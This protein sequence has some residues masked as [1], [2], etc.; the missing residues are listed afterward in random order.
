MKNIKYYDAE[1]TDKSRIIDETKNVESLK[2]LL[3]SNL[4]IS[5]EE[6]LLEFVPKVI[7]SPLYNE[8][9]KF[10]ILFSPKGGS[11]IIDNILDEYSLSVLSEFSDKKWSTT[12]LSFLSAQRRETTIH[13]TWYEFRDICDGISKKDLIIV[14]RNPI[15]KWLSGVW[16]DINLEVETSKILYSYLKEKYSLDN[17]GGDNYLSDEAIQDIIFKYIKQSIESG[18]LAC[19]SHGAL[20]NESFFNLLT[21][22]N[23]SKD[24]I[25]IIDIDD[26]DVDLIDLFQ[27]FYPQIQRSEADK[28]FWTMRGIHKTI[29]DGL[30]K[31][32]QNQNDKLFS[33][34]LRNELH[35]DL[36]YYT[37][38]KEKYK[39]NFIL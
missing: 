37:L 25:K 8:T 23:I 27:K 14:I 26:G 15:Y 18:E 1:I 35:R 39:N 13:K 33:S 6:N 10:G 3:G 11:S 17:M 4:P 19:N 24:K 2:R 38:L 36:Y 32:I 9:D 28:L 7:N 31:E 20:Y 21:N 16:M 12:Y 5:Y 30:V 22:N 29:I 34:V